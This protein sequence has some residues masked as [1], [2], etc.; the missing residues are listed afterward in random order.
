VVG[1]Y[2]PI[3]GL[4]PF[5][6]HSVRLAYGANADC[7]RDGRV[8]AVQSLSGTGAPSPHTPF[9]TWTSCPCAFL[10]LRACVGTEQLLMHCVFIRHHASLDIVQGH[11]G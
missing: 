6:D 7:L 5:I 11:A 4:K 10:A 2:L 1:R 8:A 3:Q 9:H